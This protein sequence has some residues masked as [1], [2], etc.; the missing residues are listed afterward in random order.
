M[1]LFFILMSFLDFEMKFSMSFTWFYIW[2]IN[3]APD[4]SLFL[5]GRPTLWAA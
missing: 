4:I 2:F 3:D 1:F 5:A